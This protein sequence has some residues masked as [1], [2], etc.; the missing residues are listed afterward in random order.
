[1]VK[2]LDGAALVHK[3]EPKHATTVP[4]TFKNY[5]DNAFLPYIFNQL[6]VVSQVDV[7]WDSYTADSL[8]AHVRQ[9][10]GIGN[11]FRISEK[12]RTPQNW[13]NFAC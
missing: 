10:H 1:M 6:Q 9:C 8:K 12:T 11:L 3:L 7:V 4:K 2:V 5:A 13:K